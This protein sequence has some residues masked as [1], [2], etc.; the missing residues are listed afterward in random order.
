MPLKHV[1]PMKPCPSG[2]TVEYRNCLR[3]AWIAKNGYPTPPWLPTM[4]PSDYVFEDDETGEV[5]ILSENEAKTI[6]K[7]W[8]QRHPKLA[9]Q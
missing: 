4:L 5:V 9:G 3:Q 1:P 2:N 7:A 6:A 8:A